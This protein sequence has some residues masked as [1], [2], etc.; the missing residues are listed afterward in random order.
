MSSAPL[1]GSL[2]DL[3]ALVERHLAAQN[4]ANNNNS[5]TNNNLVSSNN[6]RVRSRNNN[7]N[8]SWGAGSPQQQ[9][10]SPVSQAHWGHG[11]KSLPNTARLARSH[12][13]LFHPEHLP[14][15]RSQTSLLHPDHLSMARSQ[16]S[17]LHQ[18]HFSMARSQTSL[19]HP[20]HLSLG[21]SQTSLLHPDHLSLGRSSRSQGDLLAVGRPSHPVRR[22]WTTLRGLAAIGRALSASSLSLRPK[23]RAPL[24]S[25]TVDLGQLEVTSGCPHHQN[26]LPSP[27]R[28]TWSRKLRLPEVRLGQVYATLRGRRSRA[29][30]CDSSLVSN[31]KLPNF[32]RNPQRLHCTR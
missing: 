4:L 10:A 13:S 5:P 6:N 20:D 31:T 21:R 23:R 11:T 1:S 12:T 29:V 30:S 15:A 27:H 26:T 3:L 17:L 14:L 22:K 16:T 19:L 7:N 24:S 9:Q 2:G 28:G 25:V 18:D 8:T 32:D